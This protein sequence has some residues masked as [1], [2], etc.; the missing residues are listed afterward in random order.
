MDVGEV[1]KGR[2]VALMRAICAA[3][4]VRDDNRPC[5]IKEG[6]FLGSLGAANNKKM[7]K[8]LNI[9]HVLTVASCLCPPHPDDFKYKIVDVMDKEDTDLA[10]RFDECFNFIDEAKE[11][12]GGVLVHCFAGKSRSVT[13][14]VAYLMKM[15]GM[16][17]NEALKYVR[18]KRPQASPNPGFMEQ[19]KIFE[20]SL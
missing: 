8:S 3:K 16:S 1:Y 9:T 2:V 6:L 20:K 15:H 11:T 19:L 4:V 14:V 12:G 10:K 7:L 5:Q 18:S 13:V 17:L